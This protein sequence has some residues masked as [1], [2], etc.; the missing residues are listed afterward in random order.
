M[1]IILIALAALLP[2]FVS[3]QFNIG[4]RYTELAVSESGSPLSQATI[5]GLSTAQ[6]SEMDLNND[7]VLDLVVFDRSGD[8]VK[9]FLYDP[10]ISDYAYA[11]EFEKEFPQAIDDFL[12]MKDY[13]C[14][15]FPD[16]FTSFQGSLKIYRNLGTFPL[17]WSLVVEKLESDYG[18][19]FTNILVLSGDIPSIVDID[20]D[21]DLDVLAFGNANSENSIEYHRNMSM[22]TFGTCD[23]LTFEL[24]TQCW[25]NIQ[26]PENSSM[27]EQLFCKGRVAPRRDGLEHSR[28]GLHP[29]SS[30]LLIDT[31]KD[32][33]KDLILGD[34][35][36]DRFVFGPN[37]G[38]AQTA[39]ID[40]TQ[41]TTAFPANDPT[42][43]EYLTSG[44]EIDVDHDGVLDLIASVNNTIDSSCN[45]ENIWYYRN[46]STG[47]VD[48]Q[49]QT[50]DFLL[51]DMV[52]LGDGTCPAFV[53]INND[54]LLDLVVASSFRKTPTSS[55]KARLAYFQ[56]VGSASAPAYNLVD[57]D[58][59]NLS[60]LSLTGI[61]PSF[62]N[63]D[64]DS[65][66]E[67]VLGDANGDLHYFE[68][69]PVAG[70]SNFV[71]TQPLY[72]DINSIGF[73][74]APEIVDLNGDGL[75]DLLIGEKTGVLKY[76]QNEGTSTNPS[77]TSVASIVGFGKIDI[78]FFCCGGHAVPRV[79]EDPSF[80]PGRYL[81]IG[82]DERHI[83]VYDLPSNLNDSFALLDSIVLNE[84]R[85]SPTFGDITGDGNPD[86]II[87]T[88]AGGI[89]YFQRSANYPVGQLNVIAPTAEIKLY[90]N[91]AHG[92]VNIESNRPIGKVEI[93]SI[94]GD[95][96]M[97]EV[98][99]ESRKHA[100]Q[101]HSL[102]A[103]IYLV[104]MH[105]EGSISTHRL[106]LME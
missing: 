96:L 1:R 44:F 42:R 46:A 79:S 86:L 60:Q 69:F 24:I 28:D 82:T 12:F 99:P 5:G 10:S 91:P 47:A 65:D 36:T 98:L 58:F 55:R 29:G 32:G 6:F 56:N 2:A 17:S 41:Q 43:M 27:L 19:F 100:L 106:L 4:Y 18:G 48:Y 3:A 20:S 16:V 64:G 59:A 83:L 21:G 77:F 88:Q 67:M 15:G 38:D 45:D 81:F 68:N 90:P 104:R 31:D 87:G 89:K 97:V 66:L 30:I 50:K 92:K 11:P 35:Q 22:E 72:Q 25:G 73:N 9:T 8:I 62:G 26:E 23:S 95:L 49:L 102:P 37:T 40:V 74:A 57:E 93:L 39:N 34:I 78:S 14:D 70:V 103:G 71:L 52:D 85:I 33:D 51:R 13:N 75:Q 7:G 63:L 94:S 53:D 76:F 61:C 105:H 54:G 101:V 80:G 84:G